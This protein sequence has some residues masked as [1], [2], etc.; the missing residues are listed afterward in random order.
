MADSPVLHAVLDLNEETILVSV[1]QIRD[2]LQLL[3]QDKSTYVKSQDVL[4]LYD[5]VIEQVQ[6][7]NVIREQYGK[8]LEQNRGQFSIPQMG[9][10][11]ERFSNNPCL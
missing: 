8:P 10:K 3:K 5:Q 7:L 11:Q 6:L 9:E 1:L 2:N 4:S